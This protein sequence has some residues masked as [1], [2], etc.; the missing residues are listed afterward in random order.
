M[1]QK[2]AKTS[3]TKKNATSDSLSHVVASLDLTGT[4]VMHADEEASHSRSRI[5]TISLVLIVRLFVENEFVCP[6]LGNE[7]EEHETRDSR[8]SLL[9]KGSS[10]RQLVTRSRAANSS[11]SS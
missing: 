1:T 8:K 7:K 10:S 11:F 4:S 3:A 2:M 5:C 6:S 9:M